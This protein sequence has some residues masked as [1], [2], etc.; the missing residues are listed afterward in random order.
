LDQVA[1]PPSLLRA[2]VLRFQIG[3]EDALGARGDAKS[4]AL[5]IESEVYRGKWHLQQ[6]STSLGPVVE[7]T[8]I[9]R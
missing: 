7:T 4:R 5:R 8:E 6:P 1:L 9:E 2:R 3:F